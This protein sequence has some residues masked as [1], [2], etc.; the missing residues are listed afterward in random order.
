MTLGSFHKSLMNIP[1]RMRYTNVTF[2]ESQICSCMS[3]PARI[4]IGGKQKSV[5]APEAGTLRSYKSPSTRHKMA[6]RKCCSEAI[7]LFKTPLPLRRVPRNKNAAGS[8]VQRRS[9]FLFIRSTQLFAISFCSSSLSGLTS[10]LTLSAATW[11]TMISPTSVR[12]SS[13]RP[14]PRIPSAWNWLSSVGV[15]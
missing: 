12:I 9:P 4:W 10:S 3:N 7:W 14:S 11:A 2:L 15:T 1:S 13:Y 5:S 6:F 8:S